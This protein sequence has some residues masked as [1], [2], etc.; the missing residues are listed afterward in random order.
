M[1]KKQKTVTATQLGKMPRKYNVVEPEVYEF[2]DPELIK[3]RLESKAFKH[4]EEQ[5]DSGSAK[6]NAL[7]KMILEPTHYNKTKIN[8]TLS[9]NDMNSSELL[10]HMDKLLKE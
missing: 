5:L 8:L 7:A 3:K 4:V 9:L 10:G 6:A 2:E 1:A